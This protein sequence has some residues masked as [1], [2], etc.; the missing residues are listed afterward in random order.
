MFRHAGKLASTV[1]LRGWRGRVRHQGNPS[2]GSPNYLDLC[3]VRHRCALRHVR[4]S[5]AHGTRPELHWRQHCLPPEDPIASSEP[6]GQSR[7][8][9]R[10]R[11]FGAIHLGL[12][13]ATRIS[14]PEVYGLCPRQRVNRHQWRLPDECERGRDGANAALSGEGCCAGGRVSA[15]WHQGLS[16]CAVLGADGAGWT[17]N[18]RP[19]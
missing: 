10:A 19:A 11:L 9:C 16:D 5:S 6:L 18:G 13:P 17:A 14:G 8:P 1:F 3:S 4:L 12:A 7:P 2:L 15:I